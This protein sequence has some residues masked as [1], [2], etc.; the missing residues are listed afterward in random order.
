MGLLKSPNRS[1]FGF[2]IELLPQL[3]EL[4][5][6]KALPLFDDETLQ[7]LLGK[8]PEGDNELA[9][10]F[11]YDPHELESVITPHLKEDKSFDDLYKA[12]RNK[13][14]QAKNRKKS[15]ATRKMDVRAKS[16]RIFDDVFQWNEKSKLDTLDDIAE[17]L[18]IACNPEFTAKDL[19]ANAH[20]IKALIKDLPN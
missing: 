4:P 16:E 7:R 10:L 19:R 20:A 6:V 11:Y 15:D 1:W 3:E 5:S 9:G 12:F 2:N 18:E 13:E 8:L 17:F 14:R